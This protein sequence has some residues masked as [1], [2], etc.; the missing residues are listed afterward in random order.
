[1]AALAGEGKKILVIADL[2]LHPGKTVM[3]IAAI[4]ITMDDL[5]EIGPEES[6]GLLE[7]FLVDLADIL[8]ICSFLS[9]RIIYSS[10]SCKEHEDYHS[11]FSQGRD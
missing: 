6:V 10:K 9:P 11:P 3:Q 1:M 7:S 4:Q 8:V 2:A 5:L